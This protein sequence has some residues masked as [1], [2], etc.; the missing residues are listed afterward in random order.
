MYTWYCTAQHTYIHT[1]C[2]KIKI[3]HPLR[4]TSDSVSSKPWGGHSVVINSGIGNISSGALHRRTTRR[5]QY[6]LHVATKPS[7]ENCPRVCVCI[8][9]PLY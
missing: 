5:I 8:L 3:T 2:F 1:V 6:A 9:S 4:R 7:F